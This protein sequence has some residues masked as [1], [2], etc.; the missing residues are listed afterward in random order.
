MVAF[1]KCKGGGRRSAV[2]STAPLMAVFT[3]CTRSR[4]AIV[5]DVSSSGVRL[6]GPDL[7]K[8]G[9]D[10]V[11]AIETVQAFGSV[12]WSDHGEC[13]IAFDQPL[14][15][16]SEELLQSKVRLARGLPFDIRAAFDNWVLGSGR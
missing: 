1:G 3:T 11:V 13:G 10:L 5:A 2:R 16:E 7:P 15:L 9:E 4:S 12:A 14:P 8:M 6:R